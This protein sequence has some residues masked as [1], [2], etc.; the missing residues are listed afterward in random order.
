MLKRVR[1]GIQDRIK[2]LLQVDGLQVKVRELEETL[3]S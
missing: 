2:Q 3:S 1:V